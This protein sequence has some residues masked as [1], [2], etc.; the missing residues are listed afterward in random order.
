M[1]DATIERQL[2]TLTQQDWAVYHHAFRYFE[3][4]F[5][6]RPPLVLAGSD[7]TAPG[8]RSILALREQLERQQ[9][10]CMLLE[11]DVNHS[12]VRSMLGAAELRL[13][14]ADVL[15]QQLPADGTYVQLLQQ[16]AAAVADCLGGAQ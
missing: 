10:A 5:A 12:E 16:L 7:N 8:I 15:G 9:L 13:V 11:P 1:L 2:A 6:L 4:Q 3:R 14:T